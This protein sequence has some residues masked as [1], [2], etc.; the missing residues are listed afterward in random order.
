MGHYLKPEE[1]IIYDIEYIKNRSVW[2]DF[3]LT[4]KT[5]VAVFKGEGAK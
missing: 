1:K 3:K 2:M 4:L 5:F